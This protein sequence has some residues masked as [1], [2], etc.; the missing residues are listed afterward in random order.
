MNG[1][2]ETEYERNC[3]FCVYKTLALGSTPILV[4]FDYIIFILFC[5]WYFMENMLYW[6]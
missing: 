2:T 6:S 3:R 1:F 5:S 4:L